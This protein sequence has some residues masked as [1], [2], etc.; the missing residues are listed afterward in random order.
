MR[1]GLTYDLKSEYLAEGWSD[2]DAAE[3]D[4]DDTIAAFESVIRGMGHQPIRIGHARALIQKLAAGE[5]WDLVFN[6]AEGRHGLSRESQVPAIL[7]VYDIPYTFSDPL[8]LG[9]ALHKGLA[10]HVV[11]AAGIAT[12]DF[13]VVEDLAQLE[14]LRFPY[15]L[16]V[17]PVAEGTSK[18]IT[19][20]SLVQQ[21][22]Q[23]Q[24]VVAELLARYRQPVLVETFLPG[25][26][27]TVGILGTGPDA[28][29]VGSSEVLLLQGAEQGVYSYQNK[30][31]WI[32]KVTYRLGDRDD[33]QVRDAENVALSAWR[34]LGCRDGGRVDVR[35]DAQGKM[36]FIEVNP[37]AGLNPEIS[38]LSI[39]LGMA[40]F[41]YVDFIQG[42]LRSAAQRAGLTL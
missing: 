17:K 19:G 2:E 35:A 16:F 41:P 13:V 33:P 18:G 28:H 30:H 24:P 26:E 21:P 36:N 42:I 37:L 20:K 15:P 31:D 39:L 29:V 3:F 6:I 27:L 14:L 12:A 9:V 22:S 7:D 38:D 10:K 1:I 23:L 8:V 40:N 4:R 11:R 32:G 5:R 25:R 34:A